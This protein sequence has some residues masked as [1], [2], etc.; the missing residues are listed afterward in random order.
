[1]SKHI[2]I[3]QTRFSMTLS[4]SSL[5]I[6]FN[7]AVIANQQLSGGGGGAVVVIHPVLSI[8]TD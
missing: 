6:T 2:W 3:R 1:M 8:P 4:H 7:D 5:G